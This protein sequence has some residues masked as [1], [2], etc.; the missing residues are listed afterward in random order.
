MLKIEFV[1]KP[2]PQRKFLGQ[3]A[4][5]VISTKPLRNKYHSYANSARKLKMRDYLLT[6]PMNQ[7]LPLQTNI[8]WEYR[9][10]NS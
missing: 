8:F 3:I 7:I 5:L 10:K 4:S 6:H 2:S 1:V 9:H